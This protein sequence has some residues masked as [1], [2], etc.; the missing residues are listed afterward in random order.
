MTDEYSTE[1]RK[2]MIALIKKNAKRE[3]LT[4]AEFDQM[5]GRV[6]TSEGERKDEDHRI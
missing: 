3:Y 1:W 6:S 2:E 4:Q 5:T